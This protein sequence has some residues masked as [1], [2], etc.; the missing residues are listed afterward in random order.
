MLR[1]DFRLSCDP[2]NQVVSSINAVSGIVSVSSK[3]K[4][5]LMSVDQLC[6]NL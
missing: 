6:N 4:G 1:I 3:Y 2:K 5:W